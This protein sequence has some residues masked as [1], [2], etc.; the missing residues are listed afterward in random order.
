MCWIRLTYVRSFIIEPL[1]H[2]KLAGVDGIPLIDKVHGVSSFPL[3]I[4]P[5]S[6][7]EVLGQIECSEKRNVNGWWRDCRAQCL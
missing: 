3:T 1:I 5:A 4:P 7:I 6:E 2:Q